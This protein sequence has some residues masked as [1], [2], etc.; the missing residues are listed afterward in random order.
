MLE[1]YKIFYEHLKENSYRCVLALNGNLPERSFFERGLPI[2]AADGA[3]NTLQ[4]FGLVPNVVIG[5][6][7]SVQK[8]IAS[9]IEVIFRQD[10]NSCDFEKALEYLK[11]QDLL[12]A[13]IVGVNG[14]FIDHILNNIN[15]FLKHRCIFYADPILGQI[16]QKGE[17][18]S[19]KLPVNTKISLIGFLEAKVSTQGLRWELEHYSMSFPGKNSCFNRT[20]TESITI[21]VESGFCLVMIYL[22]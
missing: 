2:I 1:K 5:D 9:D 3:L 15:I 16:L 19:F 18:T 14:G 13:I 22:D 10:Q 17:Q 11:S 20:Q 8:P 21:T 7:D 6:L 4:A 12:P